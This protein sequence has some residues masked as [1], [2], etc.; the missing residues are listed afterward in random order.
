MRPSNS[1]TDSSSSSSTGSDIEDTFLR[2]CRNGD[3]SVITDFLGKREQ[4]VYNFDISCKGQSKSNL[5]WTPLHLATYFGHKEVAD[6]LLLKGAEINAV[7]D[8]GDT[9]LHKASFIGREDLVMLLLQYNADVSIIN[10]EGRLPR[11]MTPA[12]ELGDEIAKLLRAA[13]TTEMLR[14]E[15]KLLSH[16][17]EG[18]IEM[19]Q[20]LL[21]DPNPPNINCVDVQGNSSLHCAAYRGHKEVAVLLLQNGIDTMI[22]NQR[23]QLAL[24][25]ARDAQTL[26]VLSVKSARKVQKTATRFEGPLLK[27]SRFLG[28]KPVWAVLERGVLNYYASRAD[29]TMDVKRRDMRRKDYKYLD[30]AKVAPIPSDLASFVIHF[31]DGAIHRLCVVSNGELSQVERQKWINAVNEHA[32]FSAHYLW[33]LEKRQNSEEEMGNMGL[34]VVIRQRRLTMVL[35]LIPILSHSNETPWMH[36]GRIEFG[37]RQF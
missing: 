23:G 22:R 37:Q 4:K 30:S 26:Q 34:S 27:R 33:G 1:S 18:H 3:M 13:E 15:G 8:N 17:R 6:Q 2:A 28:W 35:L 14:K 31:N 7:N 11:D 21:K 24:D 10:G 25:L 9:P 5:G 36:D 12:N 16:A 29:S 32:A 20:K 19:V